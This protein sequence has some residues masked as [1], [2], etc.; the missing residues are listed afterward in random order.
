MLKKLT[1]IAIVTLALYNAVPAVA[2]DFND[3]ISLDFLLGDNTPKK[4][5]PKAA[6]K[7]EKKPAEKKSD[8]FD[9]FDLG[10]EEEKP[11]STEKKTSSA[12]K[13]QAPAA[14]K[15]PAFK[16]PSIDLVTKVKK[17]LSFS[18]EE[19][20]YWI[21]ENPDVNRCLDNGQTM[22]IYLVTRYTDAPA[23][24][25][26][27]S[28]GADMQTHCTPQYDALFMA[29][30]N[31][32]SL[33][34]LDVL[35]NNGANL[36]AKD[37]DG[38]TALHL[39]AA[40]NPNQNIITAL[41]DNGLNPNAKNRFGQTPLHLSAFNNKN[42]K[43][44]QNLLDYGADINAKDNLSRTPLMAAAIAENNEM[45]Q[46]LISRGADIKL[47]DNN[48]L[49][50]LAYHN[51][52]SYLKKDEFNQKT[53]STLADKL[54]ASFD[55]ITNE[56]LKFNTLL[57]QSPKTENP[58]ETASIA[59][60]NNA[61][62]D[63]T[64]E[65]GCTTLINAIKTNAPRALITKLLDAGANPDF[66]CQNGTTPLMLTAENAVEFP[67]E[68]ANTAAL[69]IAAKADVNKQNNLGKTALMYALN[70]QNIEFITTLINKGADVNIKDSSNETALSYALKQNCPENI[71]ITLIKA[72][73]DLSLEDNSGETPLSYALKNRL[74]ENIII[75]LVNASSDINTL[76]PDTLDDTPLLYAV[77]NDLSS[78]I[79]KQM[80]KK[81]ADPK[82]RD[83]NGFNTYDILKNN[84]YFK[85][86][87]KNKTRKDNLGL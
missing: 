44:T 69:L 77:K 11:A 38:N 35:I 63:L 18:L 42:L 10:M 56:H 62:V 7:K 36:I 27:L 3:E 48:N 40:F 26:L 82:I 19:V 45:M 46:Y 80:L 76:L 34:V 59:L 22:L 65:N 39:A 81:G 67:A 73:A 29:A 32:P 83:K 75:S 24:E 5:A 31:N 28:S 21:A 50:V 85:D 64:D 87:V 33:E 20:E 23:V 68:A 15:K 70:S 16:A 51:K 66:S 37:K 53:F 14:K 17:S 61:D 78:G 55:F 54:N 74:S 84:R 25:L 57:T 4:S 79:V 6:P 71:I 47:F 13:K 8:S 30:L 52:T 9:D 72:N 86:A 60:K 58:E 2:V 43:I 41:I 49:N 12:V 1:L